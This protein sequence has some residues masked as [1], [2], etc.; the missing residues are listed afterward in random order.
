MEE[1]IE[2]SV[3][4]LEKGKCL[5]HTFSVRGIVFPTLHMEVK[6]IWVGFTKSNFLT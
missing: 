5:L 3:Q 2:S 1:L 4:G 6:N